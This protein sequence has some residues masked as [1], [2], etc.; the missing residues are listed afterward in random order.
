VGAPIST[1]RCRSVP[2]C[3]MPIRVRRSAT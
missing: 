3:A 2:W 1:C